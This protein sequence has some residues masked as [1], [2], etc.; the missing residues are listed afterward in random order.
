MPRSAVRTF[1]F[2][3]LRDYTAF[4]ESRG[5]AQ[6][7]RLLRAFRRIVRAEVASRKGAEI[8]TE[9]DS[10]YVVFE[11]P[12]DALR[13]AISIQRKAKK[14]T[15]QQPD[16]PM[17]LGIGINTGEAIEHDD[18]YVGAAVIVAS[19]LATQA[20]PG[21]ILVTD[22]VRGLLR[23]AAVASLRDEGAWTLKGIAEPLRV[24]AVAHDRVP[25]SPAPA[26]RLPALLV[27]APTDAR[28]GLVMCPELVQRERA[29]EQLL[30]HLGAAASGGT[31][32]VAVAGEAGAGKSRL[33]REVAALAHDDGFYVLGGRSHARAAPPY[34]PFVAALRPYAN[35]RG[36]E[37]LR[38]LLGPLVVELRRLLPELATPAAAPVDMPDEE[39]RDRFY[40]TIQLLL[41]DAAATRPVLLV[42]E[43]FHDADAASRDLLLS[44]AATLRASLCIVL[45]F[46]NEE[47]GPT[48]PLR[49]VLAELERDHRLARITVRPL[50]AEGVQRMTRA[51][52]GER[53]T[54]ALARAVHER[55]GGLP[56]YVEELLKTA[57]DG[58]A[59][60]QLPLPRSIAD[61]VQQRLARLAA[62]RGS[63]AVALLELLAVSGM[64]LGHELLVQISGREERNVEI[65]LDAS[66]DAQLIERPD[67]ATLLYQF[68]HGL[69]REAVEAQIPR[70]R[71]RDLHA[72]LAATLEVLPA[73]ARS[74]SVIARHYLA[75]GHRDR[76]VRYAREAA[77]DATH[78]GA[79]A[80]AI[81]MLRAALDASRSTPDEGPVLEELAA[82]LQASGQAA[83]AEGALLRAYELAIAGRET[84]ERLATL[85][86]A[87]AAVLRMQGRRTDAA[88]A[89]DRAAAR[90]GT[91]ATPLLARA[92]VMRAAIA[93]ADG[94]AARTM[95]I[96]DDALATARQAGSAREIVAAMTLAGAAAARLGRGAGIGTLREATAFGLANGL[97][98]EVVDAYIELERGERQ[99]GSWADAR[100]AAEDGLRIA[101]ERGLEFAQ[102]RLLAQLARDHISQG[103]YD[104][105]R[106]VAEQAV[107]LGR[108]GT[109]AATNALAT[110]AEVLTMQGDHTGALTILDAASAE[111][112]RAEPDSYAGY[113]ARRARALLGAGRTEEAARAV[114]AGI[115]IHLAATRGTGIL[116]FLIAADIA[117]ARRDR[118]AIGRLR[119][120]AARHFAAVDAPTVHVLTAELTAIADLCEGRLSDAAQAFDLV[121]MAYDAL[122]VPVRA[123]Y[124]RAT[125]ASIRITAGLE[126][127]R[128]RRELAKAREDLASRGAGAYA[129]VIDRDRPALKRQAAPTSS[130]SEADLRTALL[131]ARG[132]TDPRIASELGVTVTA[133]SRRVARVLDKLGVRTR[134]Q[135]ATWVVQRQATAPEVVAGG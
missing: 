133:A 32:I 120:D 55:S 80:S 116:T 40:R 87:L 57:L 72:Q 11:L 101:R 79:Y 59:T 2:A 20:P 117:E 61:A 83:E 126:P 15:E 104:R 37:V 102:A 19:R 26:M 36:T 21:A 64:P 9:G 31:R 45:T 105:A 69:T 130:L 66:V 125:A 106:D 51:L 8:K 110:L 24:Y 60:E 39:R 109:I 17:R 16:L 74:A 124:R 78:V 46:R 75:S 65:D 77:A 43:D 25:G 122:G 95:S 28:A 84:E 63:A 1:L 112:E 62:E 131:V 30:D 42:L 5:D 44:L 22:M 82:A 94:D 52:L 128:A 90:L 71:R 98:A 6:A 100:R 70:T 53:A 38:R 12:G 41:E 47:V 103:E 34:E 132:Y 123:A 49:P 23:T 7:T 48:H 50:D 114:D 135:L 68:R 121:A 107:A 111:A 91:E 89:A 3:D 58:P 115:A 67:T 134:A 96:A 129:A 85:D 92:L 76:A 127:D 54:P 73:S 18:G 14:H 86:L 10:F 56:F 119:D 33:V 93:W 113:L 88:I 13:C 97:W 27:A 99:V 4:V 29:L 118:D 81:D 35:A 108:P